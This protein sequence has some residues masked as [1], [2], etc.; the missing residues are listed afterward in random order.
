[1]TIDLNALSANEIADGVR[2]GTFSAEAVTQACLDRINAREDSVMAW[3]FL[4]PELALSQARAVD[5]APEKG[6]LAGVPV[7]VKD[8]IDTRDMPTGMGSPVYDGHRPSVDAACVA[9]LRSAGAIILGKTVTCEFAG[10]TPR[11]TVNPLDP[12]RTPGGSSSGS[13]AAVADLMTPVAL[14]TQ[15]G[16]S[17]LRPS[18]YCGIIGF[19]PS[20]D[21]FSLKGVFP[22]AE[23]LDTL[24][25]H[26]R[27]IDDIELVTSALLSRDHK[28]AP[29]MPRPPV[30]GLCKTWMW[31]DAQ[32]ESRAAVEAAAEALKAAGANIRDLDLPEEFEWLG[33][34]RGIINARERAAVMAGEWETDRDRLSEQLRNTVQAGLDTPFE[35]YLDAM[36]LMETCRARMNQA[37]EGCDVLLTPAVDGEAP[38]GLDDTGSPRFQALWTMLHVPTITLPTHTGPNGLPV[39]IQLVAPY[40]ADRALMAIVRWTLGAIAA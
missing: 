25:L 3:E 37:F 40:R 39:G 27:T 29:E 7:G 5:A 12:T 22:A 6:M 19:K 24:G 14:G 13:C 18:S 1:M 34:V 38:I 9:R 8:I 21:T 2:S 15:T 32:P 23:S 31:D 11:K 20:F 28:P 33:D 26:A 36:Y 4:D 16:G 17:V 35:E 10:L 30:V